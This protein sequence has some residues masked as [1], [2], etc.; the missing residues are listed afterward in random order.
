MAAAPFVARAA[1]AKV[2]ILVLLSLGFVALGLWMVGVL[3]GQPKPPFPWAGWLG[4]LFFGPC[5][6]ILARRLFDR[7]DQVVIDARGVYSKSWSRKTVPWSEITAIESATVN[8]QKF[9]CISL[10]QPEHYPP[11][12]ILGHAMRAN[13]ALGF[14]DLALSVT[15]TDRRFPELVEA[16]S[17]HC[18]DPRILRYV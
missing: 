8:R 17:A 18:P 13:R 7:D 2:A 5:A 1:A 6:I 12:S 16:I 10:A 4:I 15:G 14:G 11:D 3:D 9:L